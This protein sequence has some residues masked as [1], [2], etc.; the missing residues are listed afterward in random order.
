MLCN[1]KKGWGGGRNPLSPWGFFFWCLNC[2]FIEKHFDFRGSK[3]LCDLAWVIR[4][5]PG[6]LTVPTELERHRSF[7][8]QVPAGALKTWDRTVLCSFPTYKQHACFSVHLTRLFLSLNSSHYMESKTGL[9]SQ[10]CS[11]DFFRHRESLTG[12]PEG[13]LVQGDKSPQR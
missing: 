7:K 3:K 10:K 4:S 9:F 6:E 13:R 8:V 2:D 11:Q 1:K 12:M 5:F